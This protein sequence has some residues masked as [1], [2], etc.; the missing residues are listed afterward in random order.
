MAEIV[1]LLEQAAAGK[2]PPLLLIEGDEYLARHSARELADAI[3]PEKDRALNLVLL[4]ASAGAREIAAHLVTVAMFAAP[5]AVVV[6]GAEAFAEEVDAARELA[7]ARDL[8]QGR[9][10]RDAARRLL[11]LVRP[12]GWG[13]AELAFGSKSG[14][15]AAKWRK[16]V[17]AAPEDADKGW[18]AELSAFALAQDIVAPPEDLQALIGALERGLPPRTHLILVAESLPPRHPLVR[19]AQE[20]GAHLKRRAERRGRTVDTLDISALVAEELGPLKKKLARDAELELKNRLGDDLRLIASELGKLALH[21][22][23]RPQITREDVEAIVAP[24]REEEFF[25]LAEAVGEGDLGKALQL[26]GDE[27]RRKTNASSVALPFLGGVASAVRKALTDS[28]RYASAGPRELGYNEYQSKLFPQL[29]QELSA[30]KQ[31]VP[32][33]FAAWLGYKRARRRP[34]S[35]WRNA[36]VRCAEVDFELKNGADPRLCMERLLVEVCAR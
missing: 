24:V 16:E 36:L 11:K 35:F 31:K 34:R 32:H 20:K 4:D 14:A 19:L 28:A 1:A 5:K 22:G 7:R 2:A 21:A 30:K 25:A 33:P 15:S 10:Q 26:F 18:L 8:W 29:E 17:G 6:E 9:R 3:V 27:L 12:V 13:A 23:E